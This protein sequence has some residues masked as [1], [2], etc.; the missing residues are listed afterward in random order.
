MQEQSCGAREKEGTCS[1]LRGNMCTLCCPAVT[2]MSSRM[3]PSNVVNEG[4]D[5][6][7]H[8]LPLDLRAKLVALV[9]A[10][11]DLP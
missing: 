7:K 4:G 9:P 3:T 2:L 8:P 10:P 5:I 11:T 1:T 6:T